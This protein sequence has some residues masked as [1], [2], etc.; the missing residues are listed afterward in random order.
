MIT[1][2]STSMI[3]EAA[4]TNKPVYVIKLN[5]VKNDYRFQ[6]F[7]DLF[8]DLGII[9]FFDG[10]IENWTYEKLYESRRVAKVILE[11]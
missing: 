5:S 1:C 2:D 3:S 6:R 8:K 11:N 4:T 10:R 9:R 7:F